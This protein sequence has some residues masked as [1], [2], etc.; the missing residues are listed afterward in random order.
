MKVQVP[1]WD[2][3]WQ[4]VEPGIDAQEAAERAV[5]R[6]ILSRCAFDRI[7]GELIRVLIEDA[8]E[9]TEWAVDTEVSFTCYAH[10]T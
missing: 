7:G 2:D 3:T 8:G 6:L 4:D 10:K 1:D 5:E 9:T